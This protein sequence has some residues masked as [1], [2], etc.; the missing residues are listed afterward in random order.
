L[1]AARAALRHCYRAART[2]GI[3]RLTRLLR[4][5][6]VGVSL[7]VNCCY[8]SAVASSALAFSL[9]T[10]ETRLLSAFACLWRSDARVATRA[11][12][13]ID[14]CWTWR[15]CWLRISLA[16]DMDAGG[17]ILGLL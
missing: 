2:P 9:L 16:G 10:S 5:V 15:W 8:S 11:V 13:V 3:S 12:F 4:L 6:V 17:C 14:L 7:H 1:R